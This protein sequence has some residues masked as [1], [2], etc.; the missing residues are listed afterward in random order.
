MRNILIA[1]LFC[2]SFVFTSAA[3]SSDAKT[4]LLKKSDP[5]IKVSKISKAAPCQVTQE[6]ILK[7]LQQLKAETKMESSIGSKTDD[8]PGLGTP[9]CSVK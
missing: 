3:F 2:F 4:E 8:L 1:A 5:K 7:E 6:K 9:G